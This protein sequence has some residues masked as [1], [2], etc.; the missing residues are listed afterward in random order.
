MDHYPPVN[1]PAAA[2]PRSGTA[3]RTGAASRAGLAEA[4]PVV[5]ISTGTARNGA[6][7]TTASTR[8]RT[9]IIVKH[10]CLRW[11]G[12]IMGGRLAACRSC[13][14][15]AATRL[16]RLLSPLPSQLAR[17][18]RHSPPLPLCLSV[19]WVRAATRSPRRSSRRAKLLASTRRIRP[20]RRRRRSAGRYSGGHLRRHLDRRHLGRPRLDR[21]R[22]DRRRLGR[23]WRRRHTL[24]FHVIRAMARKRQ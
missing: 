11:M 17:L 16:L 15:P 4:I 3:W 18:H 23:R 20:Y 19:S 2:V 22:L 13:T 24:S 5:T 14:T 21:P 12:G 7:A 6:C 8:L 9:S 10:R 1:H